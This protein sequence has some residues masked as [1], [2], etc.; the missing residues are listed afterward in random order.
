MTRD[1]ARLALFSWLC[2]YLESRGHFHNEGLE[3]GRSDEAALILNSITPYG[4]GD[5]RVAVFFGCA[6]DLDAT[7]PVVSRWVSECVDAARREIPDTVA[8]AGELVV[9]CVAHPMPG[10]TP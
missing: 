10:L 7:G 5:P 4:V 2:D 9:S 3:V 8:A 6:M 1:D